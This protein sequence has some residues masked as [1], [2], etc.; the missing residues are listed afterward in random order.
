MNCD[1][2]VRRGEVREREEETKEAPGE[3]MAGGGYCMFGGVSKMPQEEN[4]PRFE[5]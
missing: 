5:D 1:L 3:D 4:E 2:G